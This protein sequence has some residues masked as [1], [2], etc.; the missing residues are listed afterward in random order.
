M[1]KD[2]LGNISLSF[3]GSAGV[4][5]RYGGFETFLEHCGPAIARNISHVYVTCDGRYYGG[6]PAAY[7][8]MKRVFIA[9]P[10][11]GPW[12][13]LHD[14]VA[15]LRVYRRSTHI[16][17][18]GVSG[19]MWF[20]MFRA[21]C[22]IGGKTLVVNIDGVEWRRKKFSLA[23][24]GLLRLF[25]AMAQ[26]FSGVVIYDNPA[27]FTFVLPPC[28]SKAVHI[29]YSGDHVIRLPSVRRI[30]ST[31]L[32]I[33]RIE[34]ENN[35]GMLLEGFLA[36]KLKSYTIVGNWAASDYGR[37]LRASLANEPRVRLLDPIYDAMTLAQ[38]REEC[39][40][41]IHGHS[42]GGTNPSLVEMIFY[43]CML[44]CFDVSFNRETAGG[45][46]RY[47]SKAGE[48]ADLL[49]TVDDCGGQ[50][51]KNYR[52]H[53]MRDAIADRYLSAV[54]KNQTL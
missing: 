6:E 47:F 44:L 51:R 18:L 49:S 8:G 31:A 33:C 38:L 1:A 5:N 37:S 24:R 14:L 17:A 25:D 36:S 22:A 40:Y 46:A 30:A 16:V 10:A 20:P 13:V 11:N 42:V 29:A 54:Q 4:P 26:I 52:R 50:C 32:T 41:Y 27:L 2:R 43:D 3:I 45:C 7:E 34:P 35:I 15:F 9:I 19:G 23:Q 21:L 12:S 28:R 48:L 39:E 53:Y